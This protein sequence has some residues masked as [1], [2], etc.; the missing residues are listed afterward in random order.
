MIHILWP[1]YLIVSLVTIF[2]SQIKIFEVDVTVWKNHALADLKI[3]CFF[4]ISRFNGMPLRRFLVFNFIEI[5]NCYPNN[6]RTRS[7]HAGIFKVD[8]LGLKLTFSQMIRVISSPSISTTGFA[9]LIRPAHA[10]DEES[11]RRTIFDNILKI[12]ISKTAKWGK[13]PDEF[14]HHFG[15]IFQVWPIRVKIRNAA[16]HRQ[17]VTG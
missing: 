11:P 2:H 17:W 9:T 4:T 7:I 14:T 1:V 5:G 15:I 10:A 8:M 6:I 16:K 12:C 13:C 3:M